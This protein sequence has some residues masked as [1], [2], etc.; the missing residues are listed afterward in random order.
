MRQLECLKHQF[1][2]TQGVQIVTISPGKTQKSREGILNSASEEI[3]GLNDWNNRM[4]L[5]W[6]LYIKNTNKH[7][8]WY[9]TV[10][11]F[12]NEWKVKK[13]TK[14]IYWTQKKTKHVYSL[15]KYSSSRETWRVGCVLVVLWSHMSAEQ[16]SLQFLEA[17]KC[18]IRVKVYFSSFW[19]TK[20][21]RMPR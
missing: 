5:G 16:V 20:P 8:I 9:K 2:M 14:S 15:P 7:E 4:Q 18:V 17:H 6:I 21:S 10:F 1:K 11:L 3:K 13:N 19:T 12:T